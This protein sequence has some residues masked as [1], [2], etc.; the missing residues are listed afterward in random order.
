M[1]DDWRLAIVLSDE[2]QAR[3]LGRL[4]GGDELEHDL[5][6]RF[7]DRVVVSV[8]GPQLFC[9][10]GSREQAE[11]ARALIGELASSH[12]WDAKLALA[13]WHPV[14]ERWED[15]DRAVETDDRPGDPEHEE[16]M[17]RE[18]AQSAQEGFP[19][20]EVRIRCG[21][22]GEARALS[23]R[24]ADEAL[25]NVRRW[26][27]VLVGADDEDSA[28]QLADRVRGEIGGGAEVTI[29]GNA[30]AVYAGRPW[31]PFT[32]LGGLAG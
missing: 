20:W 19:E 5:D 18:R 30:L 31:S 29:D 1:S 23:Q 17:A 14:A 32:V 3:S 13:R 2:G 21:S 7:A 26:H 10:A 12:G 4:L 28:Q 16:R 15:P 6:S 11:R 25:P 24:L 9:Y 27:C 22:H 8:D